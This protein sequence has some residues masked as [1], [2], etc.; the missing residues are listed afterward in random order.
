[1]ILTLKDKKY[2]KYKDVK[3]ITLNIKFLYLKFMM[4]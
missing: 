1:M 2:C 3:E 4:K